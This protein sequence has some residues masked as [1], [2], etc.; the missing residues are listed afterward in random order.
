M[1]SSSGP[2]A[3]SAGSTGSAAAA[4]A[5]A[6]AAA[7]RKGDDDDAKLG[8]QESAR[9]KELTK[10]ISSAMAAK[11][12]AMLAMQTLS[13]ILGK[14]ASDDTW[15]WANNDHQLRR[16]RSGRDKIQDFK[17]ASDFWEQCF[18]QGNAFANHAKKTWDDHFIMTETA[19]TEDLKKLTAS[20]TKQNESAHRMH[21]EN[22]SAD[23]PDE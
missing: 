18:L 5:E 22:M 21:L 16:L 12:D 4:L 14:I 10:A 7:A 17:K 19:R 23:A 2:A 13:D 9:K 6:A 3:R 15:K 11:K 1:S 20:V 8:D